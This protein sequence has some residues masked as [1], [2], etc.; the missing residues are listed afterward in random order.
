MQQLLERLREIRQE[1]GTDQVFD[2]VGE[3]FP[4]N[5]LEK[6]FRDLYARRTDETAVKD[7]IV[8]D[9][10]P[11]RFRAI[12]ESALEG[13]ARKAL[14]LSA[15]VGKSVEARERR[16]VPEAIEKFFVQAAPVVGLRPKATG[17]ESHVY[18]VGKVPRLLVQRGDALEPRFGRLGREYHRIG[19]DKELLKR[20]PTLEWVTPGHPLFEVV[21][22]ASLEHVQEHLQRGA[23]FFDIQRAEPYCLDLFA[24][25]IKDGRGNTRHRRLFVV[26]T[27]ATG[28]MA[29]RQPTL[30]LDINPAPPG[31]PG[32]DPEALPLP[33]RTLAERFL[34]EQALLPWLEENARERAREIE[35][36]SR[37]VEIS[38]HALIDR[39]NEPLA[40]YLNRQ[41]EGRTIPGLDG[42][43][44]QAEQHVDDLNNRLEARRQEL[45]MERHCTVADMVH[46]GRAL[47]L[48]H[49]ERQSPQIAPMVRDDEV[50]RTRWPPPK[51]MRKRGAVWWKAWK[52]TIAALT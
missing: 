30:F 39:Q 31:T 12:T 19:F 24:A 47:V 1:L 23:V 20:D 17:A 44:A 43:I 48:P 7:R 51:R 14:N 15:I 32:L 16:L 5:R 29:V 28:V 9:I 8:R 25:S 36:V 41:V 18:R 11:E 40:D 42:L 3:V 27:K 34:Y 45:D 50:E 38:L 10:D 26:E 52:P 35:R 6:L 21:R 37:H 33:A 46:L 2:V 4:A 49:P 22:E 13:L